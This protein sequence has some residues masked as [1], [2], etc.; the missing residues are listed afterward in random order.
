MRRLL[1]LLAAFAAAVSVACAACF[2]TA[3]AYVAATWGDEEGLWESA[4]L[5]GAGAGYF[6]LLI[7][8]PLAAVFGIPLYVLSVR[9][10]WVSASSY[11]A[12]G[13]VVSL[14]VAGLEWAVMESPVPDWLVALAIVLG[15]TAATF[16]FWSVARP[17]RWS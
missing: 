10:G 9:Q 14:A 15:G 12:T 7:L 5:L 2:L 4:F 17:D 16:A 6:A 8:P 1:K 13:F 3:F 11:A